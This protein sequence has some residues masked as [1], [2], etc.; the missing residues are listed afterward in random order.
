LK[1]NVTLQCSLQNVA[2]VK[3]IKISNQTPEPRKAEAIP[4]REKKVS[5]KHHFIKHDS[6]REHENH[7]FNMCVSCGFVCLKRISGVLNVMLVQKKYSLHF[8]IFIIGHYDTQDMVF[9]LK[10]MTQKEHQLIKNTTNF[11]DLWSL[12]W[13]DTYDKGVNKNSDFY[14]KA[15]AKYNSIKNGVYV[16]GVL[17]KL[18]DILKDQICAPLWDS[19]DWEFPKGRLEQNDM[20]H[21]ACA[22]RELYEETGIETYE[23]AHLDKVGNLVEHVTG[24]NYIMYMYEYFV[25]EIKTVRQMMVDKS[26]PKQSVEIGQIKF[27]PMD[28]AMKIMRT[29]TDGK[30][31]LLTNLLMQIKINYPDI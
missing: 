18:D 27:F 12:I 17:Y 1:T 24:L 2:S 9:Y 19:P 22:K 10:N 31:K 28:E 6:Y 8:R 21:L 20:T 7:T 15:L 11:F 23:F 30:I 3:P 29:N 16:S 5:K 26:N 25:C 4:H 14:A 13:F